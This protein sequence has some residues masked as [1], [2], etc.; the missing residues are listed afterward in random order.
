MGSPKQLE[1][2]SSCTM[3]QALRN[4]LER[5]SCTSLIFDAERNHRYFLSMHAKL[6]FKVPCLV[7][8]GLED[9]LAHF[10]YILCIFKCKA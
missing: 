7:C 8:E 2:G 9:M 3:S 4:Y 5:Y 6:S 1:R 10:K